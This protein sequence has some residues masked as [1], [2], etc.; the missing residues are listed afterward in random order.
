[1]LF[2]SPLRSTLGSFLR[3]PAEV[4]GNEGFPLQP[5]VPSTCVGDLSQSL[6]Q[7]DPLEKGTATRSSILA[8]RIS[9]TEEPG[10]TSQ[11][12]TTQSHSVPISLCLLVMNGTCTA[13][14]LCSSVLNIMSPFTLAYVSLSGLYVPTF[15]SALPRSPSSK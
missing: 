14:I 9:W 3:S 7:E 8:W 4:G 15:A 6:G 2:R 11:G 1:M 13:H 5:W 12:V 10:G